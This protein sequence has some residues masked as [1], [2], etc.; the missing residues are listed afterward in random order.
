[1]LQTFRFIR[2]FIHFFH[3]VKM[4][5]IAQDFCLKRVLNDTEQSSEGW[6]INLNETLDDLFVAICEIYYFMM[7]K[8]T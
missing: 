6:R 7:D 8:N 5:T 3:N 4:V 2:L 1:M